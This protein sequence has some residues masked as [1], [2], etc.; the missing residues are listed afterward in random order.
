M[1]PPVVV[2]VSPVVVEVVDVLVVEV[3]PVVSVVSVV[4]VVE[5]V[6]DAELVPRSPGLAIAMTVPPA[7]SRAAAP[8]MSFS[9]V[10]RTT[11]LGW[12]RERVTG[13]EPAPP[14]WKAGALAVELHPQC[15]HDG[16]R[17]AG[18]RSNSR[19][20]SGNVAARAPGNGGW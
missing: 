5:V 3:V 13:I 15:P 8:R 12:G 9:V 16:S 17:P 7:K 4:S 14:A 1:P 2:V 6:A 20:A 10:L 11:D 19:S 18:A